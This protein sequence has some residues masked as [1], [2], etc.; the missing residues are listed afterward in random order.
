[1]VNLRPVPGRRA[2]GIGSKRFVNASIALPRRAAGAGLGGTID[3]WRTFQ[4]LDRSQ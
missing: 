2:Y 4:F 3:D 1:M